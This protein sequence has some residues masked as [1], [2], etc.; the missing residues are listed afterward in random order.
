VVD[1]LLWLIFSFESS[2]LVL[3]LLLLL[4]LLLFSQTDPNPCKELMLA[5]NNAA[6]KKKKKK[7]KVVKSIKLYAI[8]VSHFGNKLDPSETASGVYNN[9]VRR[10]SHVRSSLRGVVCACVGPLF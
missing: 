4:L 8:P 1:F 10:L 9:L 6:K 2:D 5:L 7:N 3:L